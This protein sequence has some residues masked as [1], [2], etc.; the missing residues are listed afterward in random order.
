MSSS[1]IEEELDDEVRLMLNGIHY[2]AKL[3]PI[4]QEFIV[5]IDGIQAHGIPSQ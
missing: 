4:I 1:I 2:M 5:D 3:I